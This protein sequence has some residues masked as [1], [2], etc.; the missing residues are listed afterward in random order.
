MAS[1]GGI[2]GIEISCPGGCIVFCTS[3]CSDCTQACEPTTLPAFREMTRITRTADGTQ[4]KTRVGMSDENEASDLKKYPDGTRFRV[5][6]HDVS[7]TT[8]ASVMS[9]MHHR[10]VRAAKEDH[11]EKISGNETGTIAE[12]AAKFTLEFD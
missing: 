12:L 6:F 7:R 1:C 2:C 11:K 10:K 8:L 5:C 9:H 3:D 4:F